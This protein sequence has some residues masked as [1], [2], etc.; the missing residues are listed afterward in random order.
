MEK[1]SDY[2]TALLIEAAIHEAEEERRSPARA[3]AALG[4]PFEVTMRVLTRP[5]ERRHVV[6]PPRSPGAQG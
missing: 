6:P 3:L 2:K 4:V 1:R 5:D